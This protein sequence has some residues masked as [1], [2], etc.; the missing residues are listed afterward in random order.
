MAAAAYSVFLNEG[1]P[2]HGEFLPIVKG[3]PVLH[4]Y[5]VHLGEDLKEYLATRP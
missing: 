4:A 1:N 2:N 5:F 3:F